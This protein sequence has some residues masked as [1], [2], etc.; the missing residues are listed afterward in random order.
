MLDP[1]A[2]AYIERL[3]EQ[4]PPLTPEQTALI[5]RIFADRRG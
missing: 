1:A 4:A 3:L 2:E 5:V